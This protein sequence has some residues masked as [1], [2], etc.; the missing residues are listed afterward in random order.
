MFHTKS[1]SF[2]MNLYKANLLPHLSRHNYPLRFHF[3]ITFLGA[4]FDRTLFISKP[5][6]RLKNKFFPY[7]KALLCISASTLGT[8]QQAPFTS[9]QSFSLALFHLRFTRIVAVSQRYQRYQVGTPFPSGQS[10][11][12]R[13]HLVLLYSSLRRRPCILYVP[14]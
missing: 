2:S 11:H 13:L 8:F 14:L 9:V 4:T 1:T 5:L 12:R 6:S 10:C 3:T 7:F